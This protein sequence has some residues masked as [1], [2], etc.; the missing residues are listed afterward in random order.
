[1]SGTI[2][3]YTHTRWA[4]GSHVYVHVLGTHFSQTKKRRA[5]GSRIYAVGRYKLESTAIVLATARSLPTEHGET[6]N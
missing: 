1:M 6:R 3:A 5:M 2:H 4:M